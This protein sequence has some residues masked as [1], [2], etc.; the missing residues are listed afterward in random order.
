VE[1]GDGTVT[2]SIRDNGQGF[3]VPHE[4]G[5]LVKIGKLGL[6]GMFER[7]QLVGGTLTVESQPGEATTVVAQIPYQQ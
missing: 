7:A 2:I 4:L 5:Q 1:F 6:T 3:K